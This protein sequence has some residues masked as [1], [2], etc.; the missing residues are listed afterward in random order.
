MHAVTPEHAG[1][2]SH[3]KVIDTSETRIVMQGFENGEPSPACSTSPARW[4]SAPR[5]RN[6]FSLFGRC[7]DLKLIVDAGK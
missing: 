5:W 6:D 4:R 7:T 3:F 2:Q 1:R